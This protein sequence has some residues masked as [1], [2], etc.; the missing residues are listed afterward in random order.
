[1][2][3]PRQRR[4]RLVRMGLAPPIPPISIR[5]SYEFID[6]RTPP[7]GEA[8]GQFN[9]HV[10]WVNKAASRIGYTGAKCYDAKDRRCRNGGDMKRA[11]DENAFPVRW[12]LPYHY[13]HPTVP[14]KAD[15]AAI[16]L[17]AD[18]PISVADFKRNPGLGRY[19][20]ERLRKL[21][22]DDE[23]LTTSQT[24]FLT[25]KGVERRNWWLMAMRRARILT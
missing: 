15:Q 2:D 4:I 18:T 24:I 6:D 14:S 19:N 22:D 5:R 23:L 7:E 16:M 3:T 9:S 1:M 13:P 20:F 17:L 10:E 21:F 11:Q 25:A 8:D 12:Y